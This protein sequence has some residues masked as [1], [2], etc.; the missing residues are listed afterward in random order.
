MQTP[1]L[2][3]QN[4]EAE[5]SVLSACLL[6]P[7]AVIE[8][9]D[10]LKPG[11]FYRTA[12]NVIFA[13][14]MDLYQK[15]TPV[16][17][18]TLAEALTS[19][20]KLNEVGGATYLQRVID[21]APMAVNVEHYANIVK[22][23]AVKRQIIEQSNAIMKNCY[24]SPNGAVEVLDDAQK[25]LGSITIEVKDNVRKMSDLVIN[26]IDRYEEAKDNN[27]N[28]TGIPT[29]YVFLDQLT[30]GWQPCNLIVIAGRPSMGKSAMAWCFA[31]TAAK[32]GYP[33]LIFS[34]EMSCNEY[35]DRGMAKCSQ[36][37][38]QKFRTGRFQDGDWPQITDASGYLYDLPVWID[39]SA[40]VDYNYIRRVARIHQQRHNIKFA[41]IDH[42]QLMRGDRSST[43]DREIASI[44]SSLKAMAK[45]LNIPV[46]LLSQLNRA[47]E[48]R[49]VTDRRPRLSDLRDS[50][51]IEQD[52]DV[53]AFL[54]RHFVYSKDDVDRGIA[55]LDLKKQ[56]SGP[57]GMVKL[58][59]NER[60][61]TFFELAQEITA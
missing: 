60:I 6:S 61:T 52:A 23:C 15:S 37:N 8:S 35:T 31:E 53:V 1:N 55:E 57:T 24:S 46:M 28:I 20:G 41:I 25:R 54:Y 22:G 58:F 19:S 33:T 30:S 39:D 11:H 3:P 47:L 45:E 12:N 18:V 26:A 16:D 14:M 10:I 13:H 59:W 49:P 2:P 48:Q 17:L 38:S 56:R 32:N 5:E 4:I 36:V 7:G 21:T 27:K 44:T 51:N 9:K 42:L 40:A 50:G 34:L 29:G 43:R